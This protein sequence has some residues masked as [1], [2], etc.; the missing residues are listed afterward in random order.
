MPGGGFPVSQI[1]SGFKKWCITN[2]VDSTEHDFLWQDVADENERL[3][4]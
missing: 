2:A 3:Q 4:R 1:A